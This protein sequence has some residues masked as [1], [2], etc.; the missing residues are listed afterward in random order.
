MASS[1][2]HDG[3]SAADAAVGAGGGEPG[4]GA[5]VDEVAFQLRERGHDGDEELALPAG[6]VGTGEGSGQHA[7]A[8]AARVEL[9]GD[10]QDL[11]DRSA[12]AVELPHHEDVAAAEVVPGRG[13]PRP[14]SPAAGE[15]VLEELG[16]ARVAEGV[17]LGDEVRLLVCHT[18]SVSET[19][20]QR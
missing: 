20:A 3:G 13:Q 6:G 7:Y 16:G 9:V 15:L 17:A 10:G 4:H 14:F 18:G 2:V 5:L 1:G 8:D 12:E 11:L 19:I